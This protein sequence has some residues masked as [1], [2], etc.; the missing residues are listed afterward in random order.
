M[1][2]YAG[3]VKLVA[4]IA[5]GQN[6]IACS[7]VFDYV[8]REPGRKIVFIMIDDIYDNRDTS[9]N[10]TWIY[11]TDFEFLNREGIEHIY[12]P[13]RARRITGC[14]CF[15]PA[16]RRR[17]TAFRHEKDFVKVADLGRRQRLYTL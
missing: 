13:A 3:G 7:R 4:H 1:E 5:K 11:E 6:P 10:L 2:Q 9:E 16:F 8:S 15:L 12:E 17:I 14:A